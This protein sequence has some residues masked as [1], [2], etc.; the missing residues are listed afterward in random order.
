MYPRVSFHPLKSAL[1]AAQDQILEVLVRIT[2]PARA[3]ARLPLNLAL[4]ID[5]SGSMAGEKLET[6]R[7]VG[8]AALRRLRPQD[9]FSVI[10]FSGEARV[11]LPSTSG[12]DA[13]LA[14]SRIRAL[15]AGG[16]TALHEGWLE[17]ATQVAAYLEGGQLSRVLLISDGEANVGLRDS[18]EIAQ[19]AAGLAARGV[20]TSTFGMG[21]HYDE[22]LL[23]Q[24]A[25]AAD[26]N[27]HY[28]ADTS[29]LADIFEAELQGLSC[30]FGRQ[31]SLG[32][33]PDA[34]LGIAL[35]DVLNDFEVTP[36]GRCRLPNLQLGRP[37]EALVRLHVPAHAVPRAGAHA[38]VTDVRVA[39]N[40]PGFGERRRLRVPLELPVVTADAHTDLPCDVWVEAYAARLAVARHKATALRAL[41]RRDYGGAY[42]AMREASG[43]LEETR[44]LPE[45]DAE[46][47]S[48]LMI[49]QAMDEHDDARARKL[50][51]SQTYRRRRGR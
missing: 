39:W 30:T 28:I 1:A 9:R 38:H 8:L 45:M 12:L 21:D 13:A 50:A 31:V 40:A 35:Q 15:R 32:I 4:V 36:T 23:E 22:E 43:L 24:L 42:A 16:G 26:G 49:M 34:A 41:R 27:Y 25:N 46:Y 44:D 19:Q 48:F 14:E 29:A 2:P 5:C 51:S 47:N 18:R 17:G 3:A 10:A 33:E 20:S 7:R 11:L 6:A 37:L